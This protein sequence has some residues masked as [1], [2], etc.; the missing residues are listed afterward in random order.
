MYKKPFE[1][2]MYKKS[3][4]FLLIRFDINHLMEE[5]CT[6]SF[7]SNLVTPRTGRIGY[8]MRSI[9]NKQLVGRTPRGD[10]HLLTPEV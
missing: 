3:E 1:D 9:N 4:V 8:V 7:S 2:L 6:T 5:V 10:P